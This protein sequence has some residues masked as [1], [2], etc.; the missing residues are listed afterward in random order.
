VITTSLT[1]ESEGEKVLNQELLQHLRRG[2]VVV[3]LVA[4]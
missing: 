2:G 1:S 3:D 4:E